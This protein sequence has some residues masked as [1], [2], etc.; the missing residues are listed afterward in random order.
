MV[1]STWMIAVLVY[2]ALGLIVVLIGFITML[3]SPR[4]R[5]LLKARV[6]VRTSLIG[7]LAFLFWPVMVLL[8][9]VWQFPAG[10]AWMIDFFGAAR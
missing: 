4:R 8:A 2:L 9:I 5:E 3:R 1:L 6:F 10:R 7:L